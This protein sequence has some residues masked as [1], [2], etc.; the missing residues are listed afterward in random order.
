[1]LGKLLNH[2]ISRVQEVWAQ[3]RAHALHFGLCLDGA[4]GPRDAP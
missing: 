1:M 4:V 2:A 3:G